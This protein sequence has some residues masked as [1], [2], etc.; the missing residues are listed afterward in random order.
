MTPTEDKEFQ[1]FFQQEIKAA[2][3]PVQ[4]LN[5]THI[6][7]PLAGQR[8][9]PSYINRLKEEHPRH[10]MMAELSARGFTNKEI[11]ALLGMSQ[12]SVNTGLRQPVLQGTLTET[13]RAAAATEDQKVVEVIKRNIVKAV[14]LYEEVLNGKKG[15]TDQ[16]I[17]C[18]E[19]F[20]NRRY[21]KPNQP[22]NR[23]TEID[24][25][26]LSDAELASM[27]PQTQGTG[28]TKE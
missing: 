25:N 14:E 9:L 15:V 21:G 12:V 17:E 16:Q 10:R 4:I 22:I 3:S 13:I 6:P 26:T 8:E 11:A 20:L 23:G 19:R 24:L 1:E 27:L 5:K 2:P 28:T 18:A 7:P